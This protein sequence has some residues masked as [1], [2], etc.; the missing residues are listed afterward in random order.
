[1]NDFPEFERKSK[2]EFS[3][4][5]KPKM[6]NQERYTPS[7]AVVYDK[8][9]FEPRTISSETLLI[10]KG[11]LDPSYHTNDN[12][13]ADATWMALQAII[14]QPLSSAKYLLVVFFGGMFL[15]TG[16]LPRV[17]LAFNGQT[18][19]NVAFNQIN[20]GD[21]SQVG[22]WF[23]DKVIGVVSPVTQS[24][25]ATLINYAQSASGNYSYQNVQQVQT[26][27]PQQLN[28]QRIFEGATSVSYTEGQR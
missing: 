24:A 10:K 8:K 25:N 15:L 16:V 5:D 12:A 23:T 26:G 9:T 14:K 19:S 11:T 13:L 22:Y 17:I 1:M 20:K 27:T 28:Q 4:G 21:A 3:K 2:P 18:A 6:S 7:Q